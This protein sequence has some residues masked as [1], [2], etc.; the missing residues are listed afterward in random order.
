MSEWNCLKLPSSAHRPTNQPT[1]QTDGR[2]LITVCGNN[3]EAISRVFLNH[4]RTDG[5]RN[6]WI[7]WTKTSGLI[8]FWNWI[9]ALSRFVLW[10]CWYFLS[11]R[12]LVPL[13][14]YQLKR[15]N[16]MFL[17]DPWPLIQSH[18]HATRHF[19]RK[20]KSQRV[21]NDEK[22]IDQLTACRQQLQ[23]QKTMAISHYWD[24][25]IQPVSE[26]FLARSAYSFLLLLQ[27][28]CTISSGSNLISLFFL[29]LAV[30]FLLAAH[31]P[32]IWATGK[33]KMGWI[34]DSLHSRHLLCRWK[35]RNCAN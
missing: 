26:L 8:C 34:G 35:L 6:P 2:T 18:Q 19:E 20:K 14:P 16:E 27:T 28:E 4:W 5:R 25:P 22:N 33:K 9:F 10:T 1:N 11:C 29:F 23:Q 7:W 32:T 15:T 17:P 12:W 3:K 21:A 13:F 31:I 24:L 30:P